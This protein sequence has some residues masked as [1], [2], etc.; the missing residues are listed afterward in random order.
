MVNFP[1]NFKFI[2]RESCLFVGPGH[3][4]VEEEAP[5]KTVERREEA[6]PSL[7]AAQQAHVASLD[8]E[9]KDLEASHAGRACM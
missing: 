6:E 7:E 5:L 2:F 8:G 3:V 1:W 4:D 9:D